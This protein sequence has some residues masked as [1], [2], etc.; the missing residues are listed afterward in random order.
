MITIRVTYHHEEGV[1]WAESADVDGFS[2]TAESL[3]ELRGLVKEGLEFH[4]GLTDFDLREE[5]EDFSPVSTVE[6]TQSFNGVQTMPASGS[7]GVFTVVAEPVP[8]WRPAGT[9]H[10]VAS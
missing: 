4:L 9:A 10:R 2:A 1:W 5:R 8:L 6:V 3:R 7:S